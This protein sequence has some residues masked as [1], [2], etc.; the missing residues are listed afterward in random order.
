VASGN[1]QDIA[2]LRRRLNITQEQ[3]ARE[4]GVTVGTVNRWE[5]GH[6]NPSPL[7]TKAIKKLTARVQRRQRRDEGDRALE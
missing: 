3:F 6:F 1:G 2:E 4:L 5:N 7:A